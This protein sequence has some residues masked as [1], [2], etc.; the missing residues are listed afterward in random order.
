M[1]GLIAIVV[2]SIHIAFGVNGFKYFRIGIVAASTWRQ[3]L[4]FGF[5]TAL[6]FT[7]STALY[8]YLITIFSSGIKYAD[9]T[10]LA[11]VGFG[12]PVLVF[13]AAFFV[14]PSVFKHSE[15]RYRI[16]KAGI[17]LAFPAATFF[18]LGYGQ[19]FVRAIAA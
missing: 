13:A 2:L 6:T 1:G 7:I 17:G 11:E 18:M 3:T 4:N 9:F 16:T 15:N 19:D 8:L 10:F 5:F 12:L 14:I